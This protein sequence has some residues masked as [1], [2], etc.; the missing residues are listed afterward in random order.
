MMQW[1]NVTSNLS[2]P[3]F[4]SADGQMPVFVIIWSC[5]KDT[6]ININR[7]VVKTFV[8]TANAQNGNHDRSP[9]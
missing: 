8:Q 4:I 2:A 9:I 6:H 7:L 3:S 5:P 1:A